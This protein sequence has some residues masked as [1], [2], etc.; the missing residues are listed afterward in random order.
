MSDTCNDCGCSKGD[1][2]E[3]F[4]IKERCPFCMGQL[5][6]CGCISK[7]LDLS[8]EEQRA[9]DD[10]IDDQEEPLRGVNA[11]WVKVL[12]RKDRIPF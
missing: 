12:D 8:Q 3:N 9:L 4:C 2:H 5:I 6:S 11:R 1:L 7:V 10:Y